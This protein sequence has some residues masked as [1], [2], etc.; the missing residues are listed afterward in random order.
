[1]ATLLQ[2]LLYQGLAPRWLRLILSP[3]GKQNEH[4]LF[5]VCWLDNSL[6]KICIGQEVLAQMMSKSELISLIQ[7]VNNVPKARLLICQWRGSFADPRDRRQ[8]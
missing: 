5:Y 4:A 8:S 1:M 3:V 6:R 7:F 2:A